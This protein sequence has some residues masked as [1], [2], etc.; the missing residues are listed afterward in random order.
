M[1]TSN[2]MIGEFAGK[3]TTLS[4]FTAISDFACSLGP[5]RTETKAQASFAVKRKFLWC[6]AY[7]RTADGTL[8]LT[9]AID[10]NLDGPNVHAV[11]QI[12]KSRWNH[13]VVVT[14]AEAATSDWLRELIR[15]G[16]ESAER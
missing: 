3:P 4:H 16:Y 8:Y 7:E 6:W 15:A 2:K 9:V 1:T 12:G 11:S 14:T 5:V 13:S 10:R